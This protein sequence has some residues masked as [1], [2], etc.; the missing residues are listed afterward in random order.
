[1]RFTVD[2]WE[3]D[4]NGKQSYD[5]PN[6]PSASFFDCPTCQSEGR[7]VLDDPYEDWKDLIADYP[8]AKE[9]QE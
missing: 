2:C 6:D 5:H 4:G 8:T 7:V 1:M 3:C 9:Y